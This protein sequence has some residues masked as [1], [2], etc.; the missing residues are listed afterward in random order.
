M[1]FAKG[2]DHLAKS[3]AC[4]SSILASPMS[5]TSFVAF[6]SSFISVSFI[7]SI[8]LDY[9]LAAFLAWML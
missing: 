5:M 3:S 1:F 4:T 8:K 6:G 2:R 9:Y 7:P